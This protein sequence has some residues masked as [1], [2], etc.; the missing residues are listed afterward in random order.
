MSNSYRIALVGDYDSSVPAHQAI[1]LALALAARYHKVAVEGVWV[2]TLQIEDADALLATYD[3]IWCVPASPYSNTRGALEAI[4]V[5]REKAI[6]FLGTCG[7]FQHALIEYARNVQGLVDAD[8]AETN[9]DASLALIVPLVCSLVEKEAELVLTEGSLLYRSYGV[10]RVVEG[11]RCS[12]GPNPEHEQ[13]LFAGSLRATAHD[14]DGAVRG[15]ELSG[16]PFFVG[17]LFQPERKSLKGELSPVVRDFVG[18]VV[19]VMVSS[20]IISH[21]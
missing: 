19:G 18:A 12:Y 16:H 11:Y 7:G 2:H 4:R 8:H 10:P 21:D 13:A 5:A 3:G 1:P 20:A 9:P 17:T 15:A 6:P 14:L